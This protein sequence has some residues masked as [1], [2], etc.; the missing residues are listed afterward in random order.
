[1]FAGN[2]LKSV[3]AL[4]LKLV[5]AKLHWTLKV[6]LERKVLAGTYCSS[7]P[8]GIVDSLVL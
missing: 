6:L 5:D 8:M 2:E 4:C 7:W 1:M 3:A